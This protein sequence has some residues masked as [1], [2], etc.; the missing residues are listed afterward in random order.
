MPMKDAYYFSHDSNARNDSKILKLRVKHSWSGYGLFWAIIEMLR[1]EETHKMQTDYDSIA[2]A[3]HSDSETIK[4]I[5]EDF[6]LFKIDKSL[7][8][9]ESLLNRMKIKQEKS[10]KAKKAAEKRW[11]KDA[12]AM[13]THSNSNANPMQLKE[14]KG[15][16]IKGNNIIE[17]HNEIFRKLWNSDGWIEPLCMKWKCDKKDFLNHLNGFR[18]D[19]ISK[20]EIKESEKDA[21]SHF[22]NWVNKGNKVPVSG[23]PNHT[24]SQKEEDFERNNW[25]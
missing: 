10:N 20:D 15:N 11:S 17:V 1:D 5:I 21:K 7:F 24:R 6:G 16:E 25:Y 2:F 19:C 18:I 23:N 4:S 22:V 3:L 9:S 14:S 8:F 12:N 13:Q